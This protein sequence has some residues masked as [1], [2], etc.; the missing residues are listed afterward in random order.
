MMWDNQAQSGTTEIFELRNNY[1]K[2]QKNNKYFWVFELKQAGKEASKQSKMFL[3][4]WITNR[5]EKAK[6]N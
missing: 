1:T 2:Q 6:A 5:N 3:D 4:F